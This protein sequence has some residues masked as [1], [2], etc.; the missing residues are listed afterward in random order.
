MVETLI[1][2][3]ANVNAI[4][5]EGRNALHMCAWNGHSDIVQILI[6]ANCDVNHVSSTQGATP[7]LISAQQGHID[8]CAILLTA[9]SQPNHVDN[10]GRNAQDVADNCGHRDIAILLESRSTNPG[11]QC[12]TLSSHA[13][14]AE[15]AAIGELEALF[16]CQK[17]QIDQR[18]NLH[19]KRDNS[20][21]HRKVMSISKLTKLLH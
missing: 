10:Y 16:D 15:T 6:E 2:L 19:E 7:L 13:S 3:G 11:D 14:T 5:S 1:E 8:A 18:N 17:S 12:P 20:R 4:D 21:K 9:G